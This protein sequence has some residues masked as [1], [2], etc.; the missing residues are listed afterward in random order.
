MINS[1]I[2]GW[3]SFLLLYLLKKIVVKIKH[4]KNNV[5]YNIDKEHTAKLLYINKILFVLI[6]NTV[7]L[8]I[9]N[10]IELLKE[11]EKHVPLI[12]DI[13]IS[14]IIVNI[15]IILLFL[16]IFK[17][18]KIL[19]NIKN[20]QLFIYIII[21]IS[22]IN[23]I[24]CSFIQ[25][26]YDYIIAKNIKIIIYTLLILIISIKLNFILFKI[27]QVLKEENLNIKSNTLKIIVFNIFISIIIIYQI[28]TVSLNLKYQKKE[29]TK[30]NVM[31]QI[32]ELL[33]II[34]LK[35]IILKKKSTD[36][37]VI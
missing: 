12:I 9:Q 26:F 21:I 30:D 36:K 8:L 6:C 14:S 24:I 28:I 10:I 2:F 23:T 13:L 11:Q 7:L 31:Y 17:I 19:T 4:Y 37:T 32:F 15:F 20:I 25:A 33:S 29:L 5:L 34:L 27:R 16:I 1:I 22:L 3:C 18:L 35:F